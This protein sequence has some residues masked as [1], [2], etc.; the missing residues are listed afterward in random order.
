ME[1]LA[2]A[3]AIGGFVI[4][5]LN[6]LFQKAFNHNMDKWLESHVVVGDLKGIGTTVLKIQAAVSQ[7]EGRQVPDQGVLLWLRELKDAAYEA[8]DLLD[9]V[10]TVVRRTLQVSTTADPSTVSVDKI[11]ADRIKYIRNTL[12]RVA[13]EWGDFKLGE[14][15]D[16]L[17]YPW[18]VSKNQLTSSFIEES[19][20]IGR[21]KDKE[22]IIDLLTSYDKCPGKNGFV[23]PV[24]GIGGIGKT[25]L[26]QLVY[27]DKRIK[28][29]FHLRI[30][31]CVSNVFDARSITKEIVEA[32]NTGKP[33]VTTSNLNMLQMNLQER[34]QPNR[35][36]IVLD[37]VW[38]D[39]R[40]QWKKLLAP[41]VDMRE[42]SKIVVTTRD[43][44]VAKLKGMMPRYFLKGL[45]HKDSWSLFEDHA[46]M[47]LLP[48]S[49]QKLKD[50]YEET[51][52]KAHG[53]P[54]A[55]RTLA[56]LFTS[57]SVEN[58]RKSM[59]QIEI[60]Q[61]QQN[62]GD[63]MP[64]LRRTYNRL[65][66]HLKQC[67]AFCS[68]FPKGYQFD[69]S[70]LV[71]IWMS[72]GFIHSNDGK[73]M[74]DTG[75]EYF[76]DL[77]CRG[78]LNHEEEKY[79]MP[80]LLNDLARYI[81]VDECSRIESGGSWE[82]CGAIRHLSLGC[83]NPN[84][85][86]LINSGTLKGLRT[87]MIFD[88]KSTR[89]DNILGGL[90]ENLHSLRVL[91]LRQSNIQEL[92]DS[93]NHSKHL[94][95]LNLSYNPIKELPG[96]V[97][98]LHNLQTLLLL[99]CEYLLELPESICKL[100]YLRHLK[101]DKSLK[102]KICKI[103]SM[104]SLQ[105]LEEFKISQSHK[106]EELKGMNEL[107]GR[108][109]IQNLE[110]VKDG[111]E[112]SQAMLA[113]KSH[114]ESLAFE[115]SQRNPTLRESR[116]DLEV[117]TQLKPHQDLRELSITCY[118]GVSSPGWMVNAMPSRIV[119]VRLCNCP[120]LKS[121]QNLGKLRFLE[122]LEIRRM[123]GVKRI[124]QDAYEDSEKEN[125][126]SLKEL[127]L[128]DMPELEV[129]SAGGSTR[130]FPC[131][132]KLVMKNCS[133]LN[134]MPSLPSTL[135]EITL[136]R[137]GLTALNNA[138]GALPKECFQDFT[139]LKTLVLKDCRQLRL[140]S[141]SS[142]IPPSLEVLE[143][144]S[145]PSLLNEPLCKAV[146]QSRSPFSFTISNGYDDLEIFSAE[147]L[148]QLTVCHLLRIE[149][150]DEL[151]PFD[152]SCVISIKYQSIPQQQGFILCLAMRNGTNYPSTHNNAVISEWLPKLASLSTLTIY[153]GLDVEFL[154]IDVLE[155]LSMLKELVLIE[156]RR[157]DS[158]SLQPLK[159]LEKLV[160][161]D[162]PFLDLSSTDGLS[163]SSLTDLEIDNSFPFTHYL[164]ELRSVKNLKIWSC[165]ELDSFSDGREAV[166][167][168]SCLQKLD[169][170]DCVNLR[171]LPADLETIPSISVRISDCPRLKVFPSGLASRISIRRRA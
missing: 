97:C 162:C 148:Q 171:S 96:S 2:I 20:V 31:I 107:R 120:K 105:E 5:F 143:I 37:D 118:G 141:E 100:S 11:L 63:I 132:A 133:N 62:D 167:Q 22:R 23:L 104:A 164:Q 26:V 13:K 169:I 89:L 92:P 135:R 158:L 108:L 16:K 14:L 1:P 46:L 40:Q 80:D 54:L 32:T 109:S 65:P 123:Q 87:L 72:Q 86:E 61:L 156:C 101:A 66:S 3:A 113:S 7:M 90:I 150:C 24:V 111:A 153:G 131:L 29:Y 116:Q 85:R 51:V 115:W 78:I 93:F 168:L 152:P 138:G 88:V 147:V 140:T 9:E 159:S 79:V 69:Q 15:D 146:Q 8:D 117:L 77:L 149:Y 144:I 28:Q 129:W 114:L 95:Y 60:W 124:D 74:E 163:S 10:M 52:Q 126:P 139:S 83:R 6:T 155:N 49:P 102:S 64:T 160:I 125:F 103:G 166:A 55:V 38:I 4:P 91:D 122:T 165:P 75:N 57:T 142:S 21:D 154:S 34:L 59:S 127:H 71:R 134:E 84:M 25:A 170:Q 44:G 48:E 36:L 17:D 43:T 94:R 157:L 81:S 53:S 45:S 128:S 82:F 110:I 68:I 39:D 73:S 98:E 130:S 67:F 136:E 106:I 47:E 18:M 121:L 161:K 112:A 35:F 12:D 27:N 145:C 19:R 42:G 151:P 41:F 137:V 33:S 70:D 58:N 99:G 50:L 56:R 76:H 30:W 119:V